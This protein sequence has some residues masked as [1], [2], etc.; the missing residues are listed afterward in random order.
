[1]CVHDDADK[2]VLAMTARYAKSLVV[3]CEPDFQERLILMDF[4]VIGSGRAVRSL[5]VLGMSHSR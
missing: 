1:M 3:W 4:S 2:I 5:L